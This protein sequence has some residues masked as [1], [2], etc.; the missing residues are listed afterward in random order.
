MLNV[1]LMRLNWQRYEGTVK[2]LVGAAGLAWDWG[3][4]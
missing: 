3:S 1:L 2:R 4:W